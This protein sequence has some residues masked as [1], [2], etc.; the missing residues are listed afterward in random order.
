[1][2]AVEPVASCPQCGE[3]K[4]PHRVCGYCGFY[5]ERQ[6]RAVDEE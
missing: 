1:M 6:V 3:P 2:T 5:N 4:A